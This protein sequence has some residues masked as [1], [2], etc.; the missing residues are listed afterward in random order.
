MKRF[1]ALMLM[2]AVA[3]IAITS[4]KET[5]PVRFE[6]FVGFVEKRCDKFSED[7]WKKANTQ[8][9]KLLKEW[10]PKKTTLHALAVA[11]A[12]VLIIAVFILLIIALIPSLVDS[13]MTFLSNINTYVR[14]IEHFIYQVNVTASENNLDIS[15]ITAYGQEMLDSVLDIL[16]SS[17]NT[18]MTTSH[19]MGSGFINLI[20]S[21][22]LAI[23]FL[24][25]KDKIMNEINRLRH[26]MY[27]DETY[28]SRT[29]FFRRCNDI[30]LNFVIYDLLDAAIVGIANAVFMMITGMSYIPLIST[31]V[32]VMNLLPTFG[33]VVGGLIGGI[34]I[35]LNNPIHAIWFIIFT[36]ILQTIDGYVIKPRLFGGSMGVSGVAILIMIIIGGNLFG[37]VGILLAIPS[38]AIFA[39]LYDEVVLPWIRNR[40]LHYESLDRA[41]EAEESEKR[42][43]EKR[44]A[45]VRAAAHE[46]ADAPVKHSVIEDVVQEEK[47]AY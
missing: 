24:N 1:F 40:R 9:E 18:I 10:I 34:I 33:P 30:M 44:E 41:K 25:G 15:D 31:I 43:P 4:C 47:P 21:F 46:M 22:I 12:A 3:V 32:G 6:K 36:I 13:I 38:T 39:F 2:A 19:S 26:A 35:L 20:I 14:T 37:A 5:L 42:E 29:K 11:I 17:I 28:D 16:P 23:Y 45:E 8:F 27:N 7:D